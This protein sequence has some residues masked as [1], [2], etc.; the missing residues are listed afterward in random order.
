[1]EPSNGFFKEKLTA[2]TGIVTQIGLAQETF[3]LLP[4]NTK[5]TSLKILMK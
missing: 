1:M 3:L 2:L 5:F 4:A